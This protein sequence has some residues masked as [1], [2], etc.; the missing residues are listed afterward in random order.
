MSNVAKMV[1]VPTSELARHLKIYR[2]G[3]YTNKAMK[4][5]QIG[6]IMPGEAAVSR[7]VSEWSPYYMSLLEDG[8]SPSASASIARATADVAKKGKL[9]SKN[10]RIIFNEIGNQVG[11]LLSAG[12]EI[13]MH[14]QAA[15]KLIFPSG[16][17]STV[18][19][20]GSIPNINAALSTAGFQVGDDISSLIGPL[21]RQ[22]YDLKPGTNIDFLNKVES[23]ASTGRMM[24]GQK[25]G[26]KGAQ[27]VP[28]DGT[29][30]NYAWMERDL[31]GAEW[32]SYIHK[33]KGKTGRWQPERRELD[34]KAR[35]EGYHRPKAY[36]EQNQFRAMEA[37][38][39][40]L[41]KRRDS[42][43][44][45]YRFTADDMLGEIDN[46]NRKISSD[47]SKGLAAWKEAGGSYKAA[48]KGVE[49]PK[50][51]VFFVRPSKGNGVTEV[52]DNVKN[53]P[54]F[55]LGDKVEKVR[56]SGHVRFTTSAKTGDYLLGT[57]RATH[58]LDPDTGRMYVLAH[59]QLDLGSN[60]GAIEKTLRSTMKSRVIS[61]TAGKQ[62]FSGLDKNEKFYPAKGEQVT[63]GKLED[64]VAKM[65][66]IIFQIRNTK[67]TLG[68]KIQA[69]DRSIG[70]GSRGQVQAEKEQER[71]NNRMRN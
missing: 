22:E 37:S 26:F 66:A 67:P 20:S 48:K 30:P 69:A 19:A 7:A 58:I 52:A 57:V 60:V 35:K 64:D 3:W 29:N 27:R 53:D 17:K 47:Y 8:L 63:G 21:L 4:P 1:K 46:I 25:G 36:L 6:A 62:S 11:Q 14:L 9:D 33:E 68:H 23:G 51:P 16:V 15:S 50:P 43:P 71:K 24:S 45:G 56:G 13:P 28:L 59:D 44:K 61:L 39:K 2:D 49:K 10:A 41:N 32:P 65:L 55:T 54:L 42:F 40:S 18:D 12:K 5:L 38:W 31:V 70:R 34:L